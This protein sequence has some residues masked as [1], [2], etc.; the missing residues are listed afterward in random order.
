M[1]LVTVRPVIGMTTGVF[2]YVS[3]RV[4]L[5]DFVSLEEKFSYRVEISVTGQMKAYYNNLHMYA[6]DM[7]PPT[8]DLG[9]DW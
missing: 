7:F 8:L 6:T 2:P 9:V 3:K 5:K 4:G 1:I